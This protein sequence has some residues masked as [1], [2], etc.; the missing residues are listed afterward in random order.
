MKVSITDTIRASKNSKLTKSSCSKIF[1]FCYSVRKTKKF[2]AIPVY[3][4]FVKYIYILL[5]DQHDII[6]SPSLIC[7]NII[8]LS[9]IVPV[10]LNNENM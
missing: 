1:K 8:D 4:I 6:I 2:V 10:M 3:S 7:L 5:Q 9:K